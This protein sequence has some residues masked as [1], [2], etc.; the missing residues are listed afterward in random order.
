[1]F[2]GFFFANSDS[3]LQV[4]ARVSTVVHQRSRPRNRGSRYPDF[5]A[6]RKIFPV[7]SHRE[8]EATALETFWNLRPTCSGKPETR[9][10]PCITGIYPQR[11]VR[12][13]LPHRHPGSGC[14]DFP[15]GS[16][17]GSRK[18]REFTGSWRSRAADTEPETARFSSVFG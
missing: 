1:M 11:R 17:D 7:P 4:S 12:P 9:E 5:P 6:R 2:P 8:N 18:A 13:R 16:E 10:F 14:R 15:L 3:G